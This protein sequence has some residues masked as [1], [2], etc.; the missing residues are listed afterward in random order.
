MELFSVVIK[1]PNQLGFLWLKWNMNESVKI[2]LIVF[3][4]GL[5][6]HEVL[7]NKQISN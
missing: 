5:R 1:E 6:R 2:S 7:N 4:F 3:Q